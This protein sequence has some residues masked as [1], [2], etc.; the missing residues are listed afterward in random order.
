MRLYGIIESERAQKGQGGHKHLV[1][2]LKAEDMERGTYDDVARIT[3]QAL[4]G[5]AVVINIRS[6]VTEQD[7]QI[8]LPDRYTKKGEKLKK[9][10]CA[11]DWDNYGKCCKCGKWDTDGSRL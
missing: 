4:T 6:L 11:H 1:T 5:G 7:Y 10:K 3:M 2:T 9:E 8:V